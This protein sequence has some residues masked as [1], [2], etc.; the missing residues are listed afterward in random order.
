LELVESHHHGA[1]VTHLPGRAWRPVCLRR[2]LRDHEDHHRPRPHRPAG[3][4]L[5]N[6]VHPDSNAMLD[7]ML[8]LR[9]SSESVS[10]SGGSWRP[11]SGAGRAVAGHHGLA[12][13]RTWMPMPLRR[14][15]GRQSSPCWQNHPGYRRCTGPH[16]SIQVPERPNRRAT[17]G[18]EVPGSAP[19]GQKGGKLVAWSGYER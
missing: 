5:Y 15:C 16:T 9:A 14:P 6:L 13:G 1:W 18:V 2:H 8:E 10:A 7:G 4:D 17:M 19:G 11:L 3:L 12:R